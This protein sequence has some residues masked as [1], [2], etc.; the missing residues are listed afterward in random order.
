MKDNAATVN[1][2]IATAKQVERMQRVKGVRGFMQANGRAAVRL[3]K[4]LYDE[5]F[6]GIEPEKS[7]KT[8][9]VTIGGVWFWYGADE[10]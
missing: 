9:G 7:W 1:E 3:T 8:Y 6:P 2:L 5:L 10:R 4:K